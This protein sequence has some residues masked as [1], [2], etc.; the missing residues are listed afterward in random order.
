MK[1][2]CDAATACGGKKENGQFSYRAVDS[3]LSQMTE[4]FN[5][6]KDYYAHLSHLCSHIPDSV[7]GKLI[8]LI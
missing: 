3:A 4:E 5:A 2:L 7:E 1:R 6:V 8:L